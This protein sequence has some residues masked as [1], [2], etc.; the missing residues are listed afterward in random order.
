MNTRKRFWILTIILVCVILLSCCVGRYELS[1]TDIFAIITGQGGNV[2]DRKLFYQ[3]RLPRTF[4]VV[5][6]GGALALAGTVYQAVFQNPLVSPDVLGVSSGCSVGGILGILFLGQ[7][8]L[9][10]QGLTFVFGMG[11]VALAMLLVSWMRG[12]KRY[13]MIIA[14]II[15]GS[16]ADSVII[17]LKYTADPNRELAAI[18]YWLMGSFQ[19]AGWDSMIRVLPFMAGAGL[20]L[21]LFRWKMKVLIL[22]DEE[23][24]GL[25]ISPHFVRNISLICATILVAVV[26]SEAGVVSWIGLIAPH[27]IRMFNGDD[28][29]KNFFQSILLGS[30]LL[31]LADICSRSLAQSEIPISIFT[32]FFGA[33]VLV[34]FLCRGKKRHEN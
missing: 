12:N 9:A 21:F 20:L 13:L 2:M 3:I 29:V 6:S 8:V 5:L 4:F 33:A 25:G 16:L 17:F 1:L 28:Y 26:V 10:A 11:T 24:D 23:A 18:E 34:I 7:S 19:N 30:I 27:L 32:S 31:L 14:G 15:V 22:G